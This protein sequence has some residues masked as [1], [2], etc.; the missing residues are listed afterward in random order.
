[1][2]ALWAVS[3]RACVPLIVDAA[4]ALGA[5]W[6]H[7]PIGCGPVAEDYT[8]YSFQAIKHLTTGDGGLLAC[9]TEADHRRGKL[10]RWYGIDR[11]AEQEDA[12]VGVDITEPGHKWHMNDVAA[13]IGLAQLRP[14]GAGSVIAAHQANAAYY[15]DR[16]AGLPVRVARELPK[17]AGAWWLY[18]LI[19][20]DEAERVA[21]M[22]HAAEAGV[23]TSR[24]HARL[25]KLTCFKEYPAGPLPGADEFYSRMCCIP[26]HWGLTIEERELVA[27]TVIGFCEHRR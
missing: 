22:R 17:A 9:A 26:V 8:C 1:M 5:A 25:D 3:R 10:L 4:H 6:D 13:T 20:A 16:F 19:W 11:D 18:T 24:V 14:G 12:R 7:W 2:D 27:D 23:Q 15:H 21:F